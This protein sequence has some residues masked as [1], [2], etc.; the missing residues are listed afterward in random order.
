MLEENIKALLKVLDYK[1]KDGTNNVYEKQYSNCNYAL[2]VDFNNKK[3]DYGTLIKIG[4]ATTS[5]F[6]KPENFIVLECVNRLLEKG[7]K[8]ENIELEKIYPSGRGHSGNLDIL[9]YDNDKKAYLMIECKTWGNEFKKEHNKMI[10]DGGQLFT[11]YALDRDTK[12]LCLYTSGLNNGKIEY[13]N[14]IVPIETEWISLSTSKEIHTHWNKSFKDNGIFEPHANPYEIKHKALTYGMLT[15]LKEED[16]GKIFNQIME[17][18]RHNVVS[19][20]PNAFNKLLNLF[21]CKIIDEDR[22]ESEELH[23]QWLDEDT[24]ESLQMRLNDLYKKGMDRFLNIKVTDY[25]EKEINNALKG[26]EAD[27]NFKQTIKDMFIDTRLKKSPNFAFKEVLDEKSFKANAK[28]VKEIVKLLQGYKFRYRQK[29]QFLGDFFELL[30]NTSMKQEAGQFFTPVPIT[31]FIISSLPIEE[32]IINKIKNGD[33][34]I[35]PVVIDYAAG[36]GHFL[37]EYMEQV[38]N[39]LEKYGIVLTQSEIDNFVDN[40]DISYATPTIKNKIRTWIESEKFIWA[41][42]YVYGIDLDDRLVKTA[43]VSAFFNGDGEANIIW[44]NGLDNFKSSEYIGKLKE[45]QTFDKKNNG[46][47]DILISNPPY[48]VEAFKSTLKNGKESFE[49]Y[50]SLTDNSSEIECLF[51]ERMKQLLKVGGWAGVVLPI[52]ILS[53]SGIYSK[54]REVIFKYFKVKSIVELGSGTFMK[55]GTNTIILF[56]ERRLDSDYKEIERAID[57]FF[58]DNL[59]VTVLGIENVFSKYVNNVYENLT[60]KD[61]LQ[62]INGHQIEHELY[63]DYKKDFDEDIEKIRELEKDKLLYFI[64][65]FEQQAVIVNT[66]QK[67]EEKKFLGYE[68]SE[69]RGHE[70]LKWLPSGTK[71]YN[72]NN[73]LDKTKANSYI[74]NIF[75]NKV[76]E[77]DEKLTKNIHYEYIY[78]LFEYGTSKFDKKINLNKKAKLQMNF[79][80]NFSTEKL[81]KLVELIKGVNYKKEQQTYL[82]TDN[83]I[84]TADNVSLNGELN[85]RKK[86]YIDGAINLDN[87][88][89]LIKDDIFMCFSSGSKKHVGKCAYISE[90]LKYF[91]GGFMCILRSKNKEL[92]MKYLHILLSSED[93]QNLF[94]NFCTGSNINNLSNEINNIKIPLPPIS[95][96]NKIVDEVKE[97]EKKVHEIT[98]IIYNLEDNKNDLVDKCFNASYELEQLGNIAD[99]YNGGTPD[100]SNQKYWNG[101]INWATLVDTKN[102]Y[103]NSTQRTITEEG[104]N[105]C[106]ATL[107][108]VN[109]VLFS[110]RATIGDVSISKIEVATNQGYK[111]FVCNHEKLHYEY[112]YYMLKHESKNIEELASGMTY[113][114][115]SKSMISQFKIPLPSL[116]EQIIIVEKINAI[117]NN[118]LKAKND[119]EELKIKKDLVLRK[120]L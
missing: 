20:K 25:S 59:D 30:L 103:L 6:A 4:N 1:P 91:A 76:N 35:L 33:G 113:P 104:L 109:S 96:Q 11:Y 112:L 5:N 55:T 63:N 99:I 84:L 39:I 119:I 32:M 114:E 16:S 95:I 36:S 9:I 120:Y 50:D 107:L 61:Y 69:R 58:N 19:D 42:D 75:N 78:N 46:Q 73:Q 86:V 17:I 31:R 98:L 102:K 29:H 111:N 68:F 54:T 3:I 117:E 12:Y 110:S 74:Y 115:I 79:D 81:G 118:I 82:E 13:Q 53:N 87:Q 100:T 64:L 21:V 85:I 22:N 93:F 90:N 23:F 18:L 66:G 97:I 43:K 116:E 40:L 80:T 62:L 47:F 92:N 101:N 26:I 71:L 57:K 83:A 28:I 38:Q 34:E 105:S 72:E 45:T 7:Y 51:V 37:T 88:K 15:D 14:N 41:K 52:S 49:L 48:S 77:I 106:N 108:P 70:G 8:P 89:K 67:K 2:T 44:A 24:D 60:F 27:E 10:K 94:S 56:L 65:T